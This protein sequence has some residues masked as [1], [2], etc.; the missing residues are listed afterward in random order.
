MGFTI[1]NVCYSGPVCIKARSGRFQDEARRGF[2]Q[3]VMVQGSIKGRA[4]LLFLGEHVAVRGRLGNWGYLKIKLRVGSRFEGRVR[5]LRLTKLVQRLVNLRRTGQLWGLSH[6]HSN[7]LSVAMS[8]AELLQEPTG[9]I[10]KY[11]HVG[12]G[13][14][15]HWKDDIYLN[16]CIYS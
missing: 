13:S 2:G 11:C 4:E 15:D 7:D 6:L 1:A 3:S 16:I 12:A 5:V 8:S 14:G 10:A 9:L